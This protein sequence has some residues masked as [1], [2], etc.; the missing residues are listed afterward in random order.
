MRILMTGGTGLIGQTLAD[1]L[2]AQ[3]HQVTVLSRSPQGHQEEMPGVELVE[4]NG[5]TAEGWG[6]I[7][8]T[9]DAVINLA[10]ASIAGEGLGGILIRRWSD[11]AKQ[12]I[13]QSRLNVGQAITQAV[14]AA[15]HK[16]RVLVQASAVGYYG[17]RSDEDV[18]EDDPPGDD[19][20][21]QVCVDW[22]NST[23]AVEAMGVRRVIIRTGLVLTDEGGILPVMLLPYRL[24]VG[25]PLGSGRQAVPWIH[26]RD[27]VNAI[28]YLLENEEARGAYNLTGPNPVDYDQFGKVAGKVLG[29]PS[30]IP[31]PGFVLKL[32]LGEKATLVLDGQRA[33]PRRLQAAGYNFAFSSLETALRDLLMRTKSE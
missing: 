18:T 2:L 5:R 24:F 14:E 15:A 28:L 1:E 8:E 33:V 25:G 7:I 9:T 10:G 30:L 17:P 19:F 32:L 23:Q 11:A 13:R 29:R 4:W 26:I 21:A 6:H 22:E 31:V 20:L 3:G 16:P 27:E 12:R